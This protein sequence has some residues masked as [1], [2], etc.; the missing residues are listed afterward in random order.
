MSEAT[1]SAG[2]DSA[3]LERS[4]TTDVAIATAPAIAVA[5]KHYL[6]RPAKPAPPKVEL[7]P[8]A[9]HD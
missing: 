6:E 2:N 3:R 4:L 9:K 5:V 8:G 7:P 1:Q